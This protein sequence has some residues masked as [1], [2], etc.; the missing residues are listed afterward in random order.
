MDREKYRDQDALR[1]VVGP[2][3]VPGEFHPIEFTLSYERLPN[4]DKNE[5]VVRAESQ[6]VGTIPTRYI[7]QA[8]SSIKLLGLPPFRVPGVIRSNSSGL[9]NFFI[10]RKKLLDPGVSL[11]CN[12]A[13]HED[14]VV[15]PNTRERAAGDIVVTVTLKP[16]GKLSLADSNVPPDWIE[17]RAWEQW[18]APVDIVAGAMF[19][20]DDLEK[21]L[22]SPRLGGYFVP[23]PV[24]FLREPTNEHDANAIT[25]RVHGTR[26]GYVSRHKA[27]RI[28]PFLDRHGISS[29]LLAGVLRGD[30][31][32]VG[33]EIWIERRITRAPDLSK[34][35]HIEEHEKADWPPRPGEAGHFRLSRQVGAE[36]KSTEDDTS[37]KGCLTGFFRLLGLM[38]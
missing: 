33:C 28:A 23:T 5:L 26:L 14:A 1:K 29:F 35:I 31:P 37:S 27:E 25:I 10:W 3:Y 20:L 24:Q 4:S 21:L 8:V 36:T 38:S 6:V 22:G 12:Y 11:W 30:P 32:V 19:Y 2:D 9:F 7:S 16:F 18:E 34:A 17:S 13:E 15:A